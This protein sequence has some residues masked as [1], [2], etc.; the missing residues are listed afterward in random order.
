MATGTFGPY[1]VDAQAS[2]SVGTSG[3]QQRSSTFTILSG[4]RPR[5]ATSRLLRLPTRVSWATISR[6]I[7]RPCLSVRPCRTRPS[8][9]SRWRSQLTVYGTATANASGNFS[10]QLPFTLT[11]GTI[12]L[13]VE[14]VD[15]AGNMSAASNTLTVTIV[16]VASDYNGDSYSDAALY[17]RSTISFTGTLTSG[18]PLVTDLSSLTGLVSGV[19]ITGTGVPSG[20]TITD[21]QHHRLHRHIWRPAHRWS[22]ASPARRGCLPGKT[23]PAPVSRL[24]RRSRP[25]TARR[26]SRCR[27]TRR[28]AAPEPHH[29]HHHAVGE[30]DG[31]RR[32]EP[33]RRRRGCGSLKIRRIGPANPAPFWFTSGTAFGPSNVTPFQG[34]FDGDGLD[35]S[36]VLPVQHRDLVYR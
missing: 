4:R 16:S 33:H 20:T 36:G 17:S 32:P 15:P 25:S 19:T 10:V 1:T 35:R 24:V 3:Y 5:R 2:N 23:L 8:S 31:Q 9:C 30:R 18:S 11:D 26:R 28:P 13:Y 14:A 6:A 29:D 21:R 27:R 7:T 22:R 12:S 34:D